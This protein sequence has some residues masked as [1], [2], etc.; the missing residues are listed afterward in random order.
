VVPNEIR[1]VLHIHRASERINGRYRGGNRVPSVIYQR[2]G[3]E[4]ER[5][6]GGEEE[7]RWWD[8]VEERREGRGEEKSFVMCT[9]V[10]Q[11]RKL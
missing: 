5:R 1:S 10:I 4:E 2:R 9:N 7:R 11:Y 6:R 3:G 8:R